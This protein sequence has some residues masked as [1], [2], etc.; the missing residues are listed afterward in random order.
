MRLQTANSRI[1]RRIATTTA[2]NGTKVDQVGEAGEAEQAAG[3]E[4]EEEVEVMAEE[5]AE[6]V[7]AEIPG[8]ALLCDSSRL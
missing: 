6:E 5:V 2:G 3:E 4:E 7:V 8:K 1:V